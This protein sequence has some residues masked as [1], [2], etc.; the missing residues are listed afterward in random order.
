M[1]TGEIENLTDGGLVLIVGKEDG[2]WVLEGLDEALSLLVQ[3][4][5]MVC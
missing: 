2:G 5:S 3:A 4:S 1:C